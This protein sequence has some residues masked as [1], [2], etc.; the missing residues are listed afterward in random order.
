MKIHFDLSYSS[1]S[2][3]ISHYNVKQTAAC[4]KAPTTYKICCLVEFLGSTPYHLSFL[5]FCFLA[6]CQ[7]R[8]ANFFAINREKIVPWRREVS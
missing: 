1:N 5:W 3:C 2:C 6:L 8:S 7:P 4:G